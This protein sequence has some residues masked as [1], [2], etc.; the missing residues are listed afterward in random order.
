MKKAVI[1]AIILVVL[2]PVLVT[3]IAESIVAFNYGCS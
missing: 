2:I 3:I 1:M